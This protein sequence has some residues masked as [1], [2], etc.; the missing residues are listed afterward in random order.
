M[1]KKDMSSEEAA[2]IVERFLSDNSL[3]PQE[4][5]DFVETTQ[6]DK[7]VEYYR[8]RCED[9]DPLVN[10]PEGPDEAAVI[11]LKSIIQALRSE[12]H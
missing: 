1:W 11:E 2:Q 10:R 3:Y 12:D 4:W 8:T 9:L 5:N 6:Q 7:K